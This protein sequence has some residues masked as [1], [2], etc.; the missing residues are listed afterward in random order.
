[1]RVTTP[2]LSTLLIAEYEKIV[3][4]MLDNIFGG[5]YRIK[6]FNFIMEFFRN[7]VGK[8]GEGLNREGGERFF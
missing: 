1:M 2:P 7:F 4:K 8:G 5:W 3:K 6:K